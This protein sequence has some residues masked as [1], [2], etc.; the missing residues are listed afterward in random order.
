MTSPRRLVFTRIA[1]AALA[2]TGGASAGPPA[3]GSTD[4]PPA[5]PGT[6]EP[7][8]VKATLLAERPVLVPGKTATFALHFTIKPQWHIYSNAISD[9]GGPPSAEWTLPPGFK[10]LPTLWPA[11]MRHLSPGDLLD[12][13]YENQVT[14][15][16]PISVPADAK[17]GTSVKLAAELSWM[18]C[19]DI[20]VIES[21]PVSIELPVAAQDIAQVVPDPKFPAARA[22]LAKPLNMG[23]AAEAEKAGVSVR[24]AD[25]KLR[26]QVKD[27]KALTFY[28]LADSAGPINTIA[29]CTAKGDALAIGFDPVDSAQPAK[30]APVHGIL[31]IKRSTPGAPETGVEWYE[32]S[33]PRPSGH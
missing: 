14:L 29:D 24:W 26:I 18:V 31:E 9:S 12:H 4:A 7:P 20:C 8:K 11:P 3:G 13:V 32:L 22:R 10:V 28:P 2:M 27:A 5:N 6:T 15:L 17:P 23:N 16:V 30:S 1:F 19:K 33:I 21:Q 25:T